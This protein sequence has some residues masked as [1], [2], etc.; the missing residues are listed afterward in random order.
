MEFIWAHA[1]DTYEPYYDVQ[2]TSGGPVFR[3]R[4]TLSGNHRMYLLW[5]NDQSVAVEF[6]EDS[7][8]EKCVYAWTAQ[9]FKWSRWDVV[10]HSS[11][12]SKPPAFIESYWTKKDAEE[13]R[14]RLSTK[15]GAGAIAVREVPWSEYSTIS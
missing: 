5:K 3:V 6:T 12:R 10:C 9:L 13:A 4:V 8:V 1:V 7:D 2:Y 11:S 14:G 15:H